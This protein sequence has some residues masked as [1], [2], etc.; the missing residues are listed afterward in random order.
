MN[1]VNK[2]PS[3]GIELGLEIAIRG[4]EVG[5][6]VYESATLI[7]PWQTGDIIVVGNRPERRLIIAATDSHIEVISESG[8]WNR[9]QTPS[10]FAIRLCK[11]TDLRYEYKGREALFRHF[12]AGQFTDHFKLA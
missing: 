7:R 2:E 6:E 8:C 12:I 1:I 4:D 11:S 5:V 10:E 9:Y 3:T